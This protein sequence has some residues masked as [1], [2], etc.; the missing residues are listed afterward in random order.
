MKYKINSAFIAISVVIGILFGILNEILP[1]YHNWSL[2]VIMMLITMAMFAVIMSVVLIIR[3]FAA[4][5]FAYAGKTIGLAL[6]FVIALI[7]LTGV[8]ELLYEYKVDVKVTPGS[9]QQNIIINQNNQQGFG[10][11]GQNNPQNGGNSG[12]FGVNATTSGTVTTSGYTTAGQYVFLIDNSDSMSHPSLGNDVANVRFDVVEQTVNS[13]SFNVPW[14]VYIFG[15]DVSLEADRDSNSN[16]QLSLN[17]YSATDGETYLMSAIDEIVNDVSNKNVATNI[18]VLT[19]GEPNDEDIYDNVVKKCVDNNVH[20]SCVGFG[21]A[22]EAFMEKLATDTLGAWAFCDDVSNLIVDVG[23]V[24]EYT[25]TT[26]VPSNNNNQNTS[27]NNYYPNNNSQ[28]TVNTTT[29][30]TPG[31]VSTTRTAVGNLL[32]TRWGFS[33][34]HIFLRILFLVILALI[35]SLAKALLVGDTQFNMK[36]A[37]ITFIIASIGAVMLE[38]ILLVGIIPSF[39]ARIIF[40]ATWALTI[41]PEYYDDYRGGSN[42][43]LGGYTPLEN[44]AASDFWNTPQN[45]GGT[46]SFL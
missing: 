46:N 4:N 23:T 26:N 21:D 32:G 7:G 17:R 2:G 31:S 8:F 34:L 27:S 13:Q 3:G 38:L 14:Y 35:W 6:V 10:Q 9:V 42:I 1:I 20:V 15:T 36:I 29:N 22:D 16:G 33:L 18:I 41:V 39:I 30:V 19:D 45:P 44:N 40:F 12:S 5:A 37:I 28:T 43:D 24:I 11:N 25:T